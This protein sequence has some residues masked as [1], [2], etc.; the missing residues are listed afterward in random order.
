MPR[1]GRRHPL[2]GIRVGDLLDEQAFGRVAALDDPGLEERALLGVE[3]KLGLALFFVGPVAGEAVVGENRPDV[4]V[5]ADR[6][7]RRGLLRPG[8]EVRRQGEGEARRR[9]DNRPPAAGYVHARHF[10][11]CGRLIAPPMRRA[12]ALP[13]AEPN[14]VPPELPVLTTRA[15]GAPLAFGRAGSLRYV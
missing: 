4:A 15:K 8:R 1:I 11:R 9:H 6:R 10:S 5:E 3:V 12:L 14:P 7:G 2:L 13:A